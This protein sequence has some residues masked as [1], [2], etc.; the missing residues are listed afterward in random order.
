MANGLNKFLSIAA[1]PVKKASGMISEARKLF[2]LKR[3]ILT[4]AVVFL[5]A[6]AGFTG[7]KYFTAAPAPLPPDNG[8]TASNGGYT[9]SANPYDLGDL[10]VRKSG[11][12]AGAAADVAQ[13]ALDTE[14]DTLDNPDNKDRI[15]IT[16]NLYP[17]YN[18][19]DQFYIYGAGNDNNYLSDMASRMS[20]NATPLAGS[21]I[22]QPPGATDVT[23]ATPLT[24]ATDVTAATPT[25]ATPG[26]MP[27]ATQPV[28][29]TG[30]TSASIAYNNAGAADF[31]YDEWGEFPDRA[32]SGALYN[33]TVPAPE[34]F[35]IDILSIISVDDVLISGKLSL[36]N[37]TE[38]DIINAF[39]EISLN[40]TINGVAEKET[41]FAYTKNVR[42]NSG[43]EKIVSFAAI[44][45]VKGNMAYAP[46]G[47]AL[48]AFDTRI[49]GEP[50][51]VY[52]DP[53]WA[54]LE[55]LAVGAY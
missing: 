10:L 55:V 16:A 49:D 27:G 8:N 42:I 53:D 33:R 18:V 4:G 15:S 37:N 12:D 54:Y 29:T 6:A 19:N 30:T 9:A 11:R 44:P 1:R 52:Y 7:V 45:P 20:V 50:Y 32:A 36:V 28:A 21:E 43:A 34:P 51:K 35:S 39:F 46:T 26:H 40:Y 22:A 13:A 48:A 38:F 14:P 31:L 24:A 47:V 5:C 3:I 23:A 2:N 25:G 17:A 41:C